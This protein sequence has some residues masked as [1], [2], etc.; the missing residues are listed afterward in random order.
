MALVMVM[1]NCGIKD[2]IRMGLKNAAEHYGAVPV[3]LHDIDKSNGHPTRLGM[4]QISAQVE[5]ALDQEEKA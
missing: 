3:V 1:I 5:E 2:E 4:A